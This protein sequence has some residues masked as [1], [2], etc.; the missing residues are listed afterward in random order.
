MSVFK[1]KYMNNND[2]DTLQRTNQT[3]FI[4]LDI[5]AFMFFIFKNMLIFLRSCVSPLGLQH[6]TDFIHV[7]S[8]ELLLAR[9][10]C[11]FTGMLK[12]PE[13]KQIYLFNYHQSVL[14]VCF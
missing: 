14:R 8:D 7:N 3:H 10:L 5:I 1:N 6:N 11:G 2:E 12:L 4:F 9:L 13:E